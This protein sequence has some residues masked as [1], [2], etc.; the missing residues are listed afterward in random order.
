MAFVKVKFY[1][2]ESG[3]VE[4][5]QMSDEKGAFDYWGTPGE[6]G[7]WLYKHGFEFPIREQKNY[8]VIEI[9]DQE[10]FK[11]KL[12]KGKNQLRIYMKRIQYQR[13]IRPRANP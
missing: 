13:R 3:E 11:I 4:D 12:K 10:M 2:I 1:N 6:Y 7:L 5:A 9:E 8:D